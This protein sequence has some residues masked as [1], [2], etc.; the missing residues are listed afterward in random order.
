MIEEL[1]CGCIFVQLYI[2]IYIYA[3]MVYWM[4]MLPIKF[5]RET[6]IQSRPTNITIEDSTGHKINCNLRWRRS[7]TEV[8]IGGGWKLFCRQNGLRCGS[9]ITLAVHASNCCRFYAR[10][11]KR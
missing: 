9:K 5:V 11:E 7:D 6:L 4:Q 2:Y 3:I 1:S 10:I 8:Y